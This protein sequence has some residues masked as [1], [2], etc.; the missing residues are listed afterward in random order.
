MSSKMNEK[1]NVA[2]SKTPKPHN[3][4]KGMGWIALKHARMHGTD[5]VI[6]P[7]GKLEYL[8]PDEFE[9]RLDPKDKP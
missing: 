7:N 3:A 2:F 6:R 4:L 1:T 9:K 5:L 8:T